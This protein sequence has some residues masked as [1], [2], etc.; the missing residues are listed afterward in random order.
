MKADTGLLFFSLLFSR[1]ENL[2]DLLQTRRVERGGD[3]TLLA[4]GAD[5]HGR[6]HRDRVGMLQGR[7]DV[8]TDLL[9]GVLDGRH[10]LRNPFS[11]SRVGLDLTA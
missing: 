3:D 9:F 4:V 6:Q 2:L 8:F 7:H 1:G 10:E 11:V 5:H